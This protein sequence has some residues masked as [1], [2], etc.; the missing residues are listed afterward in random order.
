MGSV[1]ISLLLFLLFLAPPALALDHRSLALV[2]NTQDPLSV[3]IGEY[4][5]E[6]RGIG[7]QNVVKVAFEPKPSLTREEFASLMTEIKSQ[8]RPHVQAY[9]IAWSAP[10]KVECMSITS[11][12]AFGFNPASCAWGCKPTP[13]SRYFNAKSSRPFSDLG[14]RPAMLL[15]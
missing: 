3:A 9:A 7:F 12:F 6:R 8:V 4:Y 14:I 1:P 11:A 10:W 13:P 2:V 15:A 5:A